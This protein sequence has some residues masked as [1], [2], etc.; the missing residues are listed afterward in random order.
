MVSGL[1]SAEENSKFAVTDKGF[2]GFAAEKAR[3]RKVHL[4][5]AKVMKPCSE[6]NPRTSVGL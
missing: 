2:I 3:G 5:A 4:D 6:L 1:V